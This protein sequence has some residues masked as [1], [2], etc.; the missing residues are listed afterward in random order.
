MAARRLRGSRVVVAIGEIGLDYHY[1]FSARSAARGVRGPA[2]AGRRGREAGHHSRPR[3]GRR[4]GRRPRATHPGAV[5]ILHSFSSGPGLLRAGLVL[6]HYVSFSG[7]ITFR[8]WRLDPAILE[9]PLDRLLVET[10][11]PYLA[12]VPQRGKRNEPAFVR[13]VAERL[14]EVRGMAGRG[15]DRHDEAR[16]PRGYSAYRHIVLRSR[17]DRHRQATVL[18]ISPSR[19]RPSSVPSRTWPPRSG[20]RPTRSCPTAGTRPRS[21]PRRWPGGSRR[22]G[23]CW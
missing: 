14:A 1:D 19:R 13:H 11:G 21:V 7:M 3:G 17:R 12:P 6:R 22:D 20:S 9:T 23:W 15:A 5:A 8:N 2:R 4:R 10:D 16:T 18:L